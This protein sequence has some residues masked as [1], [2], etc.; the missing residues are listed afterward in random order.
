MNQDSENSNSQSM[1]LPPGELGLPILGQ[2]L[3]FLFD[4]K[5]AEKQY[6]KYG[7][8]SKTSLLGRPT[9]FMIGSEAAEFVLSS[10]MECFS[11]KEGWPDN[12]KMLLGES[13]FL[14]DGEEHRRNRRLMMPAFHGQALTGYFSTMEEITQRYLAK[15]TKK[16]EFNWFDE[17]KKLTFEIASQ[18]LIGANAG[19]DVERLSKLFT[20]LTNGLFAIAPFDLPFTTLGK[21]L[22]ARDL[23]LQHLTQVVQERQQNPTN[24]VLSMLVQ[25]Q[26]E[27]GGRFSLEELKA[28]AML[29]LFAG[30]ETTTSMLTWF[31]L[32]LGRHPQVLER[33]RQEQRLLAQTGK[34]SL[35]QIGQMPYLDQIFQEI[36]R[37]RPPVGGGFRGVVKP[38]EFNGYHVPKGWLALYSIMITHKQKDVYSNPDT[39][40]PDR[41]SSNRQEHKQKPFSLIGFGG[42]ARICIGIAFAKLEMKIIAAHLLR[43]YEWEV[44]PSQNLEPFPIPTLRPK[45]GLR[46][47]FQP[48]A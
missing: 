39:F 26:D 6:A 41:F 31:C 24:D 8:I 11:W 34:L 28:Q 10:H 33:A 9:V 2:T 29:M 12:F 36:E 25:A 46:V 13:L 37:L 30:H 15:W 38:F 45:D 47:K 4:R 43:N 20:T 27:D 48:L 35:E 32:E 17:F 21:A 5:F 44:L 14:Q 22:K 42:G 16:G 7:A 3:Q 18:L 40:D 23:L 1:N 19:D